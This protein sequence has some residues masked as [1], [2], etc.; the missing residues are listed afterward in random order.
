MSWQDDTFFGV[1]AHL[2]SPLL[3]PQQSFGHLG[4]RRPLGV[5]SVQEAAGAWL[6]HHLGPQVAAHLT[7]GVIAED[8]GAVLHLRVGDDELAIFGEEKQGG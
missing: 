1:Q 6:L 5:R 8:D 7:E 2:H 4:H 3:G